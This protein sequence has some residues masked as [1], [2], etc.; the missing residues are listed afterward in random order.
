MIAGKQAMG[1]EGPTELSL[2]RYYDEVKSRIV[3]RADEIKTI[4]ATLDAGRH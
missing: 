3:A 2:L 1:G 4:M